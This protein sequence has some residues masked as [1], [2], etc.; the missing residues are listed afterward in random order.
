MNTLHMLNTIENTS[1]KNEKIS[2]LKKYEGIQPFT[3]AVIYALHPFYNFYMKK[4]PE[5][6][7]KDTAMTLEDAISWLVDKISTREL[8]GNA[9]KDAV[10]QVLSILTPDDAEV[11]CRVIRKDLRCG[12][13]ETSVN[14]AWVNNQIPIF[15]CLKAKENSTANLA[16][17]KFPAYSQLKADGMRSNFICSKNRV[18]GYSRNGKELHLH[19]VF[20]SDI[21]ILSEGEDCVFDGELVVL[22]EDGNILPRKKGNGIL[23]KAIHGTMSDEEASRVRLR[24]WD[25]IDLAT[26]YAC[27]GTTRYDSRFNKII[28]KVNRLSPALCSIIEYKIVNSMDEAI[29]HFEEELA[30]GNEGIILKNMKGVWENKRSPDLVKM[31][32]EKECDLRVVGW[33]Y[34]EAGKKWEHTV[35]SLKCESEDGKVSVNVTGMSDSLRKELYENITTYVDKIVTIRY[36][37]RICSD[38]KETSSLFLPRIVEFRHDKNDANTDDEIL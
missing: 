2:L 13:S 14:K 36:N 12:F 30:N 11:L 9:A 23:N 17:I 6:E 27:A 35:G 26:F 28:D 18:T 5:Y 37:E 34:G 38:N 33:N 19:G 25:Y 7:T 10:S 20:D 4:I 15:P 3:N 24:V 21:L 8:S 29:E 1:S 16:K 32:A 22:D 31:K